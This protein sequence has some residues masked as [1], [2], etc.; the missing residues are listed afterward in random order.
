M[1]GMSDPEQERRE[2][3]EDRRRTAVLRKTRL[4]DEE[5]EFDP[6]RGAEAIS[7][8]WRLTRE[9]WALAGK[10]IPA[11]GGAAIPWRFVPRPKQ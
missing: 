6:I 4:D 7:L 1:G 5:A 9:S 3:A 10:E 11:Y 2:R 8:A